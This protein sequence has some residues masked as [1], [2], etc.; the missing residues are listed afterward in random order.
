MS[1]PAFFVGVDPRV[2]RAR[3][4]RGFCRTDFEAQRIARITPD[5]RVDHA[6][7]RRHA[8]HQRPVFACHRPRLQLA[9]QIRL[10]SAVFSQ[11]PSGP[12]Y[13]RPADA[14]FPRAERRS[15]MAHTQ[16]SHSAGSPTSARPQ[17]ARPASAACSARGSRRPR[18]SRRAASALAYTRP[19]RVQVAAS[20]S[21]TSPNVSVCRALT[22]SPLTLTAPATTHCCSRLRDTSGIK[23]ASALSNRSPAYRSS[24]RSVSAGDVSGSIVAFCRVVGVRD[25]HRRTIYCR[26]IETW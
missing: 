6:A 18:I 8:E 9:H 5:R 3:G 17:D 26:A 10:C 24:I 19:R 11:P 22:A 2:V 1:A 7:L 15:A 14:R 4:L 23:S 12:T 13:R 21:T 16:A 20:T 25:R